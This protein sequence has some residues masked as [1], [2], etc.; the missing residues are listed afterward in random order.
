MPTEKQYK[1]KAQALLQ[2]MLPRQHA[3]SSE[4]YVVK[5]RK[6]AAAIAR[7]YDGTNTSLVVLEDQL[8]AELADTFGEDYYGPKHA[9]GHLFLKESN[10]NYVERLLRGGSKVDI[11]SIN[12]EGVLSHLARSES[13]L[14]A[15]AKASLQEE[16][17]ALQQ[18]NRT[19]GR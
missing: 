2:D 1:A 17:E 16:L 12:V 10:L 4:A 13:S 9:F 15:S 7:A 3:F 6:L 14:P 8:I 18:I 19:R 11:L 5:T